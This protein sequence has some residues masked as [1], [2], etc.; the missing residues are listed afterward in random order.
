[1]NASFEWPWKP[2]WLRAREKYPGENPRINTDN[3]P[4]FIAKDQIS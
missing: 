1:L 3:G 2:F 4:Q